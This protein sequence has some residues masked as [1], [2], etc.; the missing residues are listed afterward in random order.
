MPK[1]D[2]LWRTLW[3]FEEGKVTTDCD[4]STGLHTWQFAAK[5]EVGVVGHCLTLPDLKRNKCF[6]QVME[7]VVWEEG[8]GIV[9]GVHLIFWGFPTI[10]P[11]KKNK[12]QKKI[13]KHKKSSVLTIV[14]QNCLAL[15]QI[16]FLTHKCQQLNK[17]CF[18]NY[19]LSQWRQSD[20]WTKSSLSHQPFS[21][22]SRS[23]FTQFKMR[24]PKIVYTLHWFSWPQACV[25]KTKAVLLSRIDQT[26]SL[27]FGP[28]WRP[29]QHPRR[30]AGSLVEWSCPFSTTF[31]SPRTCLGWNGT[32]AEWEQ[33]FPNWPHSGVDP[34][35]VDIKMLPRKFGFWAGG[36][37]IT[38]TFP[39]CCVVLQC[40]FFLTQTI[41]HFQRKHGGVRTQLR[42][43][44]E[45]HHCWVAIH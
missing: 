5:I 2:R 39:I 25:L 45:E 35:R 33:N 28:Q 4:F 10:V 14:N 24:P 16:M 12:Y 37:K 23:K 1:V 21:T 13:F 7:R 15:K 6:E 26:L 42:Q 22:K 30:V 43:I 8:V 40:Q 32:L 31:H 34:T 29:V 44:A 41:S 11:P 18:W 19:D 9:S 36:V 3:C 20:A 38:A 27:K 17:F